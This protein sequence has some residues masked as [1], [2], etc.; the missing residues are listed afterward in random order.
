MD[1]YP[2]L[3]S[4]TRRGIGLFLWSAGDAAGNF[5]GVVPGLLFDRF[6]IDGEGLPGVRKV[7]VAVERGGGPDLSDLDTP[8]FEGGIINESRFLRILEMDYDLLEEVGLITVDGEMVMRL[9]LRDQID[10]G[11]AMNPQRVGGNVFTLDIDGI[12]RRSSRLDRVGALD[13][14]TSLYYQGADW[15]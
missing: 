2:R 1:Q 13:L 12:Q 5:T 11:L 15:V 6:P 14:I 7:E 9:P 3:T 10:G 8:V 4:R